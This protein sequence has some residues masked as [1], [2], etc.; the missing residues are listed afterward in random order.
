METV[1]EG[2]DI[3]VVPHRILVSAED[4]EIFA[5]DAINSNIVRITPPLSQCTVASVIFPCVTIKFHCLVHDSFAYKLFKLVL[6]FIDYY[7]GYSPGLIVI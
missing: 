2:N 4:G 5:V 1:V 6:Y 7:S 3:G